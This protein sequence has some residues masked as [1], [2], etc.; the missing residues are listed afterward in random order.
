MIRKSIFTGILDPIFHQ[1]CY[2]NWGKA[3]H[4]L[5]LKAGFHQNEKGY[6][7]RILFFLGGGGLKLDICIM[8][9]IASPLWLAVGLMRRIIYNF[10]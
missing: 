9:F 5:A 7:I 4:N 10:F 6:L 2:K 8:I 1:N 3:T